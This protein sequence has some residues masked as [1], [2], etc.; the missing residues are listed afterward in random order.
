LASPV[1]DPRRSS[2]VSTFGE[3]GACTARRSFFG[4]L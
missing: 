1:V 4:V 2:A 3:E